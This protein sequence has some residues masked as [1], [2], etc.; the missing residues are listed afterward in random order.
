MK[1]RRSVLDAI[2][3]ALAIGLGVLSFLRGQVWLGV[4]FAAIGVLRILLKLPRWIT[5]K[6]PEEIRLNLD[7]DTDRD[8]RAR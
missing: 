3:A 4:C 1:M 6:A 2:V 5:P 7:G 8:E